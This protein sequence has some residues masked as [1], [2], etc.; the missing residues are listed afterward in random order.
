MKCT[1]RQGLKLLKRVE[2]IAGF[3]ARLRSHFPEFPH[4]A[5][6]NAEGKDFDPLGFEPPGLGPWVAAVGKAVGDQK[7]GLD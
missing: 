4:V 3:I 2:D 7:D 5:V 6:A 1:A